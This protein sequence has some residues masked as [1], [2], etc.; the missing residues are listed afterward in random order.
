M[1]GG[2]VAASGFDGVLQDME[3]IGGPPLG[4]TKEKVTLTTLPQTTELHF[5]F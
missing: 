5:L 4:P 3:G 1:D 2:S